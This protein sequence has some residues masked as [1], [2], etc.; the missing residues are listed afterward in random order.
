M[1]FFESFSEA[2]QNPDKNFMLD[3][4]PEVKGKILV[5]FGGAFSAGKSSLINA[6]IGEKRLMVEIDPTTSV[7]TFVCG[8][9]LDCI[10]GINI[11]RGAVDLSVKEFGDLTH[12]GPTYYGMKA[13]QLMY[14]ITLHVS[15]F[16]WPNIAMLD[17][18]GYSKPN[19]SKHSDFSDGEISKKCLNCAD[20]IVW[21]ISAS[22]GVINL[23]EINFL[24]DLKKEIP[25]LFVISRAD[26][27]TGADLEKIR[28]LVLQTLEK[29]QID[30]EDVIFVSARKP[31]DFHMNI[32][33]MWLG[34]V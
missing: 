32:L 28:Q 34:L 23:D 10:T 3:R 27:K 21:V 19:Y 20:F 5:A 14:S 2:F 29:Y 18:P 22:A 1:D 12:D 16:K 26:C 17:T 7:P 15:K 30:F 13:G 9:K 4:P 33:K 6:L 11:L 8:G 24:K 31:K 25:K